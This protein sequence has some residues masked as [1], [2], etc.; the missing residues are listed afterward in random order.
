MRDGA[1]GGT[2]GTAG[3][4][5]GGSGC[6][7]PAGPGG[8]TMVELMIALVLGT[9]VTAGALALLI[10]QQGFYQRSDEVIYAGQSLRAVTETSARELRGVRPEDI[11][12]SRSDSVRVRYDLTRAHVCGLTTDSSTVYAYRFHAATNAALG[13]GRGTAY[14]NPFDTF[15]KY[16]PDFDATGAPSSTARDVCEAAGSPAGE[17][18]ERYREIGWTSSLDPPHRG[19]VLRVYG[20]LTY[21][22]APSGITDGAALWR[23]GDELVAPFAADGT[24]FAYYVC[25]GGSCSWHTDVT[26]ASDR[27]NIH[28]IRIHAPALGDGSGQYSVTRDL[29]YEATLRNQ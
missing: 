5:P 11:L 25:A 2:P 1:A 8:F 24:G 15:F 3:G 16:D 23:N 4:R 19:A 7:G 29:R 22:F 12:A 27:R 28:R 26:D 20:T 14:R 6:R 17:P 13:P 21:E 9:I 18:S 10:S